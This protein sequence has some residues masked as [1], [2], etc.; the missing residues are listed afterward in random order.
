MRDLGPE[1]TFRP[2]RAYACCRA[3]NPFRAAQSATSHYWDGGEVHP[4]E[5]GQAANCFE[6]ER[7]P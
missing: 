3:I 2:H 1:T 6:P 4:K 5:R 7:R